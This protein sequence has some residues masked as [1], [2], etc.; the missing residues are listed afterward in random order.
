MA[1]LTN[2]GCQ[3]GD[4][5]MQKEI[6]T[7]RRKNCCMQ[8]SEHRT[9]YFGE[10]FTARAVNANALL[11][12]YLL[13]VQKDRYDT[14]SKWQDIHWCVQSMN[15][16]RMFQKTAQL[17]WT[18]LI[19]FPFRSSGISW[20]AHKLLISNKWEPWSRNIKNVM[21][22]LKIYATWIYA[23]APDILT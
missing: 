9:L 8:T 19:T 13:M 1:S 6:W 11:L 5:E 23:N 20:V 3:C 14:I 7:T 22:A 2:T 4:T 10:V 17:N 21:R 18:A 12:I 16:H 15:T